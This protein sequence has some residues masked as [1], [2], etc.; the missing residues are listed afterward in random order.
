[1][2]PPRTDLLLVGAWA[3]VASTALQTSVSLHT[4]VTRAFTCRAAAA[5][6]SEASDIVAQQAAEIAALKKQVAELQRE[7]DDQQVART[8]ARRGRPPKR[9]AGSRRT[10]QYKLWGKLPEGFDAA[11]CAELHRLVHDFEVALV[12]WLRGHVYNLHTCEVKG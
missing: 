12:S 5:T 6:S 7:R 4:R 3:V 8:P 11:P 10:P 2:R 1:M 9:A